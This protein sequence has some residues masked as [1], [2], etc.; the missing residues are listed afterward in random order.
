[1]YYELEKT[2]N[3]RSR[4]DQLEFRLKRTVQ[5]AQEVLKESPQEY[6][7]H[8]TFLSKRKDTLLYRFRVPGAYILY[9]V[10]E[11]EPLVTLTSI[12]VFR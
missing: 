1:M 7:N 2:S 3:F 12:Q 6:Q 9:T 11:K 8:I 4:F 10:H 5:E